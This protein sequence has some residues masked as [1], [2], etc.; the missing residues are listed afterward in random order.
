MIWG[1]RVVYAADFSSSEV[2]V[3]AFRHLTIRD[4]MF[5]HEKYSEL[6]EIGHD[7]YSGEFKFCDG[8]A[9]L[10]TI[11]DRGVGTLYTREEVKYFFNPD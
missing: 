9:R 8:A 11:T 1:I 2:A 7:K 4:L 6:F 10:V 3:F 5:Y